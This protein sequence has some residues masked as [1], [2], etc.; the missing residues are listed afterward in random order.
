MSIDMLYI[1]TNKGSIKVRNEK[2]RNIIIISL[3]YR[4]Y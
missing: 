4:Q 3:L 1:N 2:T